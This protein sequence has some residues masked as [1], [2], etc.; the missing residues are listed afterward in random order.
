MKYVQ[1]N[2]VEFIRN[3]NEL[4]A[5]LHTF[6][7]AYS[8]DEYEEKGAVAF[9]SETHKSGYVLTDENDLISVFSLP[10]AREGKAAI[11]DAVSRGALT[12]DCFEGYLPEFY[13]K[14]GFVEIDRLTWDDHYAPE[15]WDYD[16]FGRP[17]IIFMT[18][19]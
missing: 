17:D 9:L 11:Q 4:P 18:R 13:E 12:L 2:F 14:F 6:V 3:I 15:T 1:T 19:T 7:T 10:G 16:R 5:H 8:V